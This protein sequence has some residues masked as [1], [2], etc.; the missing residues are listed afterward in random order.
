MTK[1]L[2]VLIN[3]N[4]LSDDTLKLLKPRLDDNVELTIAP[5][6]DNIVD[7]D[8]LINGSPKPEELEKYHQVRHIIMPWAGVSPN[9]RET[10]K[11]Y[12][13]ISLH[14]SH[15]NAA[16]TGE[17]AIALMMAAARMIPPVDKLMHNC[18]WSPR[19]NSN[20]INYVLYGRTALILGFG[21][22]GQHVGLTCQALGMEV[23]GIRRDPDKPVLTGLDAKVYPPSALH[24]L[25]P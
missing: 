15:H 10:M 11:D 12:P 9:L 1:K 25:A 18:D 22:I 24:E 3:P 14:N 7:F 6:A 2:K 17:M 16:T 21:A 20:E 13:N 5:A 19:G 8:V 23:L 4:F